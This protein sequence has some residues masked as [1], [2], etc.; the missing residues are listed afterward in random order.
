[1]AES[2]LVSVICVV[3]VSFLFFCLL[4]DPAE[5]KATI[6]VQCGPFG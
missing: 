2:G 3:G 5:A 1:M 4:V 6:A